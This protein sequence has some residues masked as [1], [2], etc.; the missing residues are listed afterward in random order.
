MGLDMSDQQKTE[1]PSTL[2]PKLLMG[3]VLWDAIAYTIKFTANRKKFV[4]ADKL[5]RQQELDNAARLLELDTGQ[6]TKT[7]HELLDRVNILRDTIQARND[8]EDQEA[9][10][11]YMARKILEAETQTNIFAVKLKNQNRKQN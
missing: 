3:M 9:A 2:S 4:N 5:E 10:R 6:D 8:Y 1:S 7:T 11:R